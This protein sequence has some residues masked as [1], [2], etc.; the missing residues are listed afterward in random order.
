MK[1]SSIQV[2]IWY[3]TYLLNL[4]LKNEKQINA[5]KNYQ[6]FSRRHQTKNDFESRALK[7]ITCDFCIVMY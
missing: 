2:F 1:E 7:Q 5:P 4:K 6:L 3:K